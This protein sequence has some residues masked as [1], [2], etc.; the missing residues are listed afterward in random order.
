VAYTLVE[1]KLVAC[2][3]ILAPHESIYHWQG[4]IEEATERG[5]LFKTT[6]AL[7][8]KALAR[9]KELHPYETPG[10]VWWEAGATPETINWIEESVA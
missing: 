3:N 10:I 1:E 6:E 5:L 4:K 2:V 9:L 7:R 8:D